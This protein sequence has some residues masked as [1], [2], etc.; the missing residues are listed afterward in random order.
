MFELFFVI[1]LPN[2]VIREYFP[3]E[4]L[5]KQECE[6]NG[7]EYAR[8]LMEQVIE[9]YPALEGFEIDCVEQTRKNKRVVKFDGQSEIL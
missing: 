7:A 9:K 5:T 2:K 8:A 4:Y 3:D 1:D 6:E